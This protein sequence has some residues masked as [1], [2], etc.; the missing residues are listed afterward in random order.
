VPH[1]LKLLGREKKSQLQESRNPLMAV[2]V[3]A[4]KIANNGGRF[5]QQE[6]WERRWRAKRKLVSGSKHR[7]GGGA[8]AVYRGKILRLY[9]KNPAI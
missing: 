3:T 1:E 2:R 4:I 9:M 7:E 5:V 8:C 6:Q